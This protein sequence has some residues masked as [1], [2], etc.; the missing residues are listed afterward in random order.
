MWGLSFV[1]LGLLFFILF[2]EGNKR[3][4]GL[5]LTAFLARTCAALIHSYVFVLPSG[6]CDAKKFERVAWEWAQIDLMSNFDPTSSYLISWL[7][8]IL[9]SIFD[10]DMLLLQ[11]FNVSLGTLTVYIVYYT[12][13]HI[14]EEKYAFTI[15]WFFALHPTIIEN[16]AVFLREVQIIFFLSLSILFL[17]K[18]FIYGRLYQ[19]VTAIICIILS[20]LFH[21]AMIAGL[22]VMM[23]VIGLVLLRRLISL[24]NSPWLKKGTIGTVFIFVIGIGLVAAMGLPSLSSIGNLERLTDADEVASS[25]GVEVENRTT[26]NAVYLA[27]MTTSNP[28]DMLWQAP[29]RSIYFLFSPFPWDI[30]A[31]PHLKGFIDSGFL[32]YI[33]F[34]MWSYRKELWENDVFRYLFYILVIFILVFS[35]G[36]S[37]FGTAIRHKSK[38]LPIFM[39]F[40]GLKSFGNM[41]QTP[42]TYT[43]IK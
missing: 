37:N 3:I 32:F 29:I 1:F 7:G 2:R 20:A 30:R 14:T 10:R 39:L 4:G 22:L 13:S 19:M 31:F 8:A 11:M 42:S 25:A 18:W 40:Y 27:G 35:F 24:I 26:G 12:A 21:G 36:A 5:L 41:Q 9:Y 16:S 28:V 43:Y 17:I 15:G 34:L 6:C 33:S 23:L 38:F